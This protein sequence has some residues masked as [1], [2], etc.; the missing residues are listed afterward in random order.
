MRTLCSSRT[1]FPEFSD[2]VNLGK[3]NP[4]YGL[5]ETIRSVLVEGI[6]SLGFCV[7]SPCLRNLSLGDDNI[8]LEVFKWRDEFN[9]GTIMTTNNLGETARKK[10]TQLLDELRQQ[11]TRQPFLDDDFS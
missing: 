7:G 5:D 2:V 9:V 3:Y 1:I 6:D 10:W 4:M 8:M 11:C